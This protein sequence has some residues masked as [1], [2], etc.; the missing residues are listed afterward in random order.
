MDALCFEDSDLFWAD[1]PG[2][3][4]EDALFDEGEEEASLWADTGDR[5]LVDHFHLDECLK[6]FEPSEVDDD[7]SSVAT[8]ST[9]AGGDDDGSVCSFKIG[10][11]RTSKL[12]DDK[13]EKPKQKRRRKL[14][15]R[16]QLF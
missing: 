12:S 14:K 3:G 5:Q 15:V 11:K 2:T 16:L 9:E 7:A 6:E 8:F 10:K 4:Q 1:E 13:V